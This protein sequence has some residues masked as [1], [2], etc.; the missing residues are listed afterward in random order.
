MKLTLPPQLDSTRE[1]IDDDSRRIIII[2]ANGS[3]KTRF[4]ERLVEETGMSMPVFR[5]SALNALY[6]ADSTDTLDGSVD[7]LYEAA[8]E[9]SP[10]CAATTIPSLSV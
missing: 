6:R 4:T 5:I 1:V 3:G 2:G 8:T 10:L 7:V 9:R